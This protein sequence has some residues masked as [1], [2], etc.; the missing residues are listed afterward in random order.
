MY[1]RLFKRRAGLAE[2]GHASYALM[3]ISLVVC[4]TSFPFASFPFAWFPLPLV[5]VRRGIVSGM[6][7]F[8]RVGRF[9]DLRRNSTYAR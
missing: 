2:C 8:A 4:F 1:L 6:S 7:G 5:A 9:I 3:A